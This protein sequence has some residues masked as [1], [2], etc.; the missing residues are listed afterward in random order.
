ML[1]RAKYACSEKV[2]Q[3][4]PCVKLALPTSKRFWGVAVTLQSV[5]SGL[6]GDAKETQVTRNLGRSSIEKQAS[7][8]YYYY[9]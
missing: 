2:V 7:F 4:Y 6:S 1:I 8:H 9:Y 3:I 5:S